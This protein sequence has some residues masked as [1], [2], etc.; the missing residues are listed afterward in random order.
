MNPRPNSQ[1]VLLVEDNQ[2]DVFFLRRALKKSG[3]P[4]NLQVV[5]DG[6]AALEYL[7]GTG[8]FADREQF[9]AP[10]LVLLDLKLPYLGGFEILSWMGE[11]PE[12][13]ELPVYVLTSS[14]EER[15]RERA[16]QL[17]AK[18][19]LV[20]PPTAEMLQDLAQQQSVA[21]E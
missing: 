10:A 8:Q 11:R 17:G 20:K 19:Y 9:P 1:P 15:D 16:T 3:L 13:K 4:W 21:G 5:M 12:L 18:A 14:P 7:G 6:Q 2:D